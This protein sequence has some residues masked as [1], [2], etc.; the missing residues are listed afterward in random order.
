[1]WRTCTLLRAWLELALRRPTSV[2]AR[3][4]AATRSSS[5]ANDFACKVIPKIREMTQKYALNISPCKRHLAPKVPA[6]LAAA[7]RL[8]KSHL[9]LRR[10]APIVPS[11]LLKFDLPLMSFELSLG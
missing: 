2:S 5:P 3:I 1:M 10:H 6:E 11:V 4:E 9:R 7:Q 8:P